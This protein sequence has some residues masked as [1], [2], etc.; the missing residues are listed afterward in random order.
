MNMRVVVFICMLLVSSVHAAHVGI[1]V[2]A[3]GKYIQFITPLIESANRYLLP[4]HQ[5]T[6]FV[7]TDGQAPQDAN[8]VSVYQQRLGWPYDTLMRCAVYVSHADLYA[9]VDYL[10]AID[11]DMLFV[12]T[13]GDE[14]LGARVATQHPGFIGQRGTYETNQIST[15]CVPSGQGSY[16]FAGGFHGGSRDEF[17]RLATTMY[18]NIMIDLEKK[19]IAVWHDESHLN[20]YF[21]DNPPTVI[22]NSSYCYPGNK[23][24]GYPKK[25]VAL[26]KNHA[27][28]RK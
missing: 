13:V 1:L 15:A 8:I 11:A 17:L 25:L 20:R 6:Y 10:F 9:N 22:L 14:I 24:T 28:F 12:D 3:T 16:Y 7:F 18:E 5:K 23:R 4:D 19:Y 21:I 26:D 27:E 2:V